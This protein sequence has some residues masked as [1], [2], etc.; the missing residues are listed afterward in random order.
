MARRRNMPLFPT[1]QPD[2]PAPLTV[3][4][5]RNVRFEEVDALGIVWHGRYPSYIEDARMAFGEKYGLGYLDMYR[6]KFIAPIVQM[7][8]D[9]HR[10]LFF[11]EGF[12]VVALLH[13]TDAVKLNFEYRIVCK[14]QMV[15]TAYTVQLLS[16][17]DR[18]VL[19]VRPNFIERFCDKWK[20]GAFN[21]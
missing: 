18:E 16:N 6:E 8:I 4:T 9:Y 3:E 19:L 12:S 20:E 13:W 21:E 11:G 7:H 1:Q 14:E 17:M 2:A 15:A 5:L 10:P